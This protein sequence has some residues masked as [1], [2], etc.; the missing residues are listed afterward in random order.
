MA[1]KNTICLWYDGTA[2]EAAQFYADHFP[3]SEVGTVLRA[4]GTTQTA[5]RATC[6][7]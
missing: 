1:N 7:W 5:M 6:S 3:D 2:E 4:P